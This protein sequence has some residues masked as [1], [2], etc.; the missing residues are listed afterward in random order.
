MEQFSVVHH[1][2]KEVVEYEL[3]SSKTEVHGLRIA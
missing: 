2:A 1:E 3:L